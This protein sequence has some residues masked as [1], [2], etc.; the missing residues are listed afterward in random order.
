MHCQVPQFQQR[1]WS[2]CL[3][4]K[5]ALPIHL[6]VC[7]WWHQTVTVVPCW[8]FL[9][10][11]A[12][13]T[14]LKLVA[15]PL[16]A[17]LPYLKPTSLA[18]RQSPVT[19]APCWPS[20]LHLAMPTKLK[21]VALPLK[22]FL[23][24]LKPTSLVVRQIPVTVA[25][26]LT[27]PSSGNGSQAETGRSSSQGISTISETQFIGSQTE[28][29]AHPLE[30]TSL[31]PLTNNDHINMETLDADIAL[32][33]PKIKAHIYSTGWIYLHYFNHV[34]SI[35]CKTQ[36]IWTPEIFVKCSFNCKLNRSS[37]GT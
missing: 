18:V 13:P 5:V 33:M 23:P 16:K 6:P 11:L 2:H 17:V 36:K 25:P 27:F 31:G 32:I 34:V 37:R 4:D 21:L 10:H 14:K 28:S 19:V 20:L 8:P 30:G 9:L 1:R 35:Y 15:L 7:H 3:L 22:A 24:Y 29:T 26:M 12:M